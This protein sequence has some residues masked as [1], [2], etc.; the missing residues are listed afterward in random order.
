MD[1]A[2]LPD[3]MV[4]RNLQSPEAGVN[5]NRRFSALGGPDTDFKLAQTME[6]PAFQAKIQR[7]VNRWKEAKTQETRDLM[8]GFLMMEGVD[9]DA[10]NLEKEELVVLP[11]NERVLLFFM[12]FIR[13][14]KAIL[15]NM[16]NKKTPIDKLTGKPGTETPE[17]MTSEE[18]TS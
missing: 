9:V 6:N 18:R 7:Y 11:E 17:K 4:P 14:F 13:S 1:K 10:S 8:E 3:R 5:P 15:E 16:G 2:G 12:G